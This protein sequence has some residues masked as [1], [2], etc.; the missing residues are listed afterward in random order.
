MTWMLGMQAAVTLMVWA[1]AAGATHAQ[2]AT[3][4]SAAA[5]R[6]TVIDL[7][8]AG[9]GLS[10]YG[11]D[12]NH[13]GLAGG[14]LGDAANPNNG[15]GRPALFRRDMA[16]VALSDLKGDV[17][18]VN[19]AEEVI[20]VVVDGGSYSSFFWKNGVF[21]PVPSAAGYQ[22]LLYGINDASVA[23]GTRSQVSNGVFSA[24]RYENG[25]V[26]DLGTWGG[27]SA[28]AVAINNAGTMAGY[29]NRP[30]RGFTLV[31]GVLVDAGGSVRPLNIFGS[32]YV[33]TQSLNS[34]GDV[35]GQ[36]A[37]ATGYLGFARVGVRTI[38]VA[39]TGATQGW[40]SGIN[41]HGSAVC[42]SDSAEGPTLHAL[43]LERGRVTDLNSLP[44]VY[45]AGWILLY[46]ANAINNDGVI[47]GTG[48][49]QSGEY[50]AY[51]L[52]PR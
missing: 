41:D 22:T 42:T 44:E 25:S 51:M 34:R 20:G 9:P 21:T 35:V 36:Y 5:A 14:Y 11:S 47:V 30:R 13:T 52:V 48:L 17:T 32:R 38:T 23:V 2:T 6:Y 8:A 50:R 49:R 28:R 29:R 33:T 3:P 15:E 4:P 7:G 19:L 43:L 39:R 10:S 31:E 24:I 18:G 37:T 45:E 26:T 46:A 40:C 16:P 27:T 12:V 1:L